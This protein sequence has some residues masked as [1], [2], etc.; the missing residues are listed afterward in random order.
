M[1][2]FNFKALKSLLFFVLLNFKYLLQFSFT[3]FKIK[4]INVSVYFKNLNFLRR[5]YLL[6]LNFIFLFLIIVED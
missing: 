2:L 5:L 4:I 1:N 6:Q 3:M